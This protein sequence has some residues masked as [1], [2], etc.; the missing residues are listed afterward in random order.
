MVK[1]I[2]NPIKFSNPMASDVEIVLKVGHKYGIDEALSIYTSKI[3][4]NHWVSLKYKYANMD[5][6]THAMHPDQTVRLLKE[7]TR[8]VLVIGNKDEDF[9]KAV[10]EM[11]Q[12]LFQEGYYKTIALINRPCSFCKKNCFAM[13]S[14]ESLGID[15]LATV[16]KFK[17]NV[18]QPKIGEYPPYAIILVS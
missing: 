18:P 5:S 14:I 8:A 15:I 13:P 4:V 17:K 3:Y 2:K 7:Y 11:E 1:Y 10:F 12:Q 9:E 16:R 6:C